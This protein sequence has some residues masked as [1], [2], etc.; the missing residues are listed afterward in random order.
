MSPLERWKEIA[1]GSDGEISLAEAALVLA[2]LEYRGL[3]VAAYLARVEQ[4]ADA[5]RRRLRRDIGPTETLI[6]LNRYLFEELGFRGNAEDYYDPR[7]SYL[8]EVLDRRLGIPITLSV[9]HIEIGRR[10]GLALH[11]V[12]FPGHFLVKCVVRDGVVVL[13]PYARGASLGLE[14]LRERLRALGGGADA[15]PEVVRHMLA[16][17]GKKEILARML[18]NLKGIYL[19][20][21]DLVRA[22]ACADR[23]LELV[24][25]AAEEYRDRAGIYLELECFRAALADL[26]NYLM[27][28][29]GARDAPAVKARVAE[30]ERRAARLN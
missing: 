29:P 30:L 17:A 27:L 6:A 8:N 15:A 16:A 7:N 19:R 10:A 13:D 20:R 9:I 2:A 11:G 18:R 3:D 4:M 12:S 25:G 23:I 22:L 26:R 28:R 1:A 24:P 21:G 5:L 14:E